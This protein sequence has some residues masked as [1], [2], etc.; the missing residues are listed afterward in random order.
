MLTGGW[1]YQFESLR[2]LKLLNVRSVS[3]AY[4]EY[5]KTDT[6]FFLSHVISATAVLSEFQA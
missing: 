2:S 3:L 6:F 5:P 4:L 1:L